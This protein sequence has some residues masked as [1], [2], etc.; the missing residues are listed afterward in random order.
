[1]RGC[2]KCKNDLKVVDVRG[3]FYG[4]VVYLESNEGHPTVEWRKTNPLGTES[5][6]AHGTNYNTHH[7]KLRILE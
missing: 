1:M 3:I 4:Y 6:A 2:L 5:Q 7:N